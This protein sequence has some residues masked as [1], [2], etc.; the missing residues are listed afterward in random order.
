MFWI[1]LFDASLLPQL[2]HDAIHPQPIARNHD[3]LFIVMPI[4]KF[5]MAQ[6]T[7]FDCNWTPKL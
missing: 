2:H 5:L 3:K 6:F 7:M 1:S 4:S